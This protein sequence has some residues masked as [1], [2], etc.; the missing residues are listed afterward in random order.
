[1]RRA[2][3]DLA[4]VERIH[5]RADERLQ[6][7]SRLI[8]QLDPDRPLQRGFARLTGPGGQV[9]TSAAAAR[10][11]GQFAVKFA[12]GEFGAIATDKAPATSRP[13][14]AQGG[15]GL[16]TGDALLMFSP[17]SQCPR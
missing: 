8:G 5:L 13:P 2:T 15:W 3:P 14:R 16:E 1:M 6:S 9:L 12:D 7:L 4:L 11:A 10:K 17:S